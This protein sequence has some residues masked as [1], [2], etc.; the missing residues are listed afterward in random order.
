MIKKEAK[1]L[2][3]LQSLVIS[4]EHLVIVSEFSKMFL[5]MGNKLYV[6]I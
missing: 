2:F 4:E 1:I 3:Q 6:Y 5:N